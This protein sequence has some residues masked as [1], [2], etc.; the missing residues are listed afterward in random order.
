MSAQMKINEKVP[1]G[2]LGSFSYYESDF[3][4]INDFIL[5]AQK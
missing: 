4:F 3:S 1:S 5:N 2:I